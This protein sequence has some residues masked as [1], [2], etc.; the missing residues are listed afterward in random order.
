[1]SPCTSSSIP[2]SSGLAFLGKRP[3]SI[4]KVPATSQ[5]SGPA[6]RLRPAGVITIAHRL[7][8]ILDYDKALVLGEGR[9]LEFDRPS[10]LLQEKSVFRSLVEASQAP[11]SDGDSAAP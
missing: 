4:G 9:V 5:A 8:T 2:W 11:H 7:S 3:K 10:V 1:M 6:V